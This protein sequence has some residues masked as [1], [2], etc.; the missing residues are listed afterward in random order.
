M[1][2]FGLMDEV[3]M[4]RDLIDLVQQKWME[5]AMEGYMKDLVDW[6]TWAIVVVVCRYLIKICSI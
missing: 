6:D 4:V 3:E 1:E 2:E 5:V